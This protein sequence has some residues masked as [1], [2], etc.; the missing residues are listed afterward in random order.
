MENWTSADVKT[1]FLSF[2]FNSSLIVGGKLDVRGRE[3]LFSFFFFNS[4][5]IVGGK[6]DVCGRED[7]FSF[8]FF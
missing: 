2:F 3:D 1:F 7:L 5:L 8:F 4:S 6:L